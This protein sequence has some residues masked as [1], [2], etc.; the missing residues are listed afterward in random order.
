MSGI[1]KQNL[2]VNMIHANIGNTPQYNLPE[3]YVIRPFET[4]DIDN[5]LW[6]HQK[7]D[8]YNQVNKELFNNQFG[9]DMDRLKRRQL[10]L[11]TSARQTIGTITAWFNND[12][13]GERYG[14][15]HWL[16][17]LPDYQGKGLAKPL[18]SVAC[19]KLVSLGHSKAYLVTSTARIPAINLYLKFGF[20]PDIR[21]SRQ[22]Q[23]W[24]KITG[25]VRYRD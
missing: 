18:L 20:K 15:I 13:Y 8:E 4:G 5:W 11:A 22:E 3:G 6:I 25:S 1:I 17:I 19:S 9:V 14:R 16:A 23:I 10:Y 12:Y 2:T 24:K 21:D 7:A